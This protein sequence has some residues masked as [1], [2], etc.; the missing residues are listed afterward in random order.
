MSI[1]TVVLTTISTEVFGVSTKIILAA[2]GAIGARG[3][4]V[5][6][7]GREVSSRQW[8]GG[9]SRVQRL[10]VQNAMWTPFIWGGK[11]TK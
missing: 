4:R 8:Y 7:A 11:N 5:A 3:T 10:F 2:T 1:L 9:Q 6:S